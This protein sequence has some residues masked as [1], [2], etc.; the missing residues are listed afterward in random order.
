MEGSTYFGDNIDDEW[1]IVDL[2]FH[3]KDPPETLE[4]HLHTRIVELV[5]KMTILQQ[6]NVLGGVSQSGKANIPSLKSLSYHLSKHGETFT[7]EQA[8][9]V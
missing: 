5:E 6:I 2:L 8:S 7:L 4:Q 1:F 9:K 3:F